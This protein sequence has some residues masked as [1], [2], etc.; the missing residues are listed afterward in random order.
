MKLSL[1]VLTA[2]K[3]AGKTIP[4]TLAQFLIGRDPQCN[5]RPSSAMVSK[6]HC[7]LMIKG[8][9]VFVR[10][11]DSTNGTF[12]NNEPVKGERELHNDDILKV[13]PLEFRAVVE[14]SP[15]SPKTFPA[16]V[17]SATAGQH[18]ED[19]A[20]MLLAMSDDAAPGGL[21]DVEEVPSGST[22]MDVVPT[23]PPET[24]EDVPKT[25]AQKPKPDAAKANANTS[26]AAKAILDKYTRR[27]RS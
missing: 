13:G 24:R 12:I 14:A 19:V 9:K 1:T 17:K 8:D 10:D 23:S 22:V 11:F 3:A 26:A 7:A 5:L 20:A 15:A 2:G 16:P 18:D 25:D 21:S 6:R 27:S 4:I